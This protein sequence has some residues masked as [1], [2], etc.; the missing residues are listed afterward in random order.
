MQT[1]VSG[2][3]ITA[4][5]IKLYMHYIYDQKYIVQMKTKICPQM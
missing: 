1:Q 5:I 2:S 3:V 4:I